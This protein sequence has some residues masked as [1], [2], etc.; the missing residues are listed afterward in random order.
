[1]TIHTAGDCSSSPKRP[2]T[3]RSIHS[4]NGSL[5]IMTSR[6]ILPIAKPLCATNGWLNCDFVWQHTYW[7][8]LFCLCCGACGPLSRADSTG[9]F[10]IIKK[11]KSGTVVWRHLA[12]PWSKGAVRRSGAVTS[13]RYL[14]GRPCQSRCRCF[15]QRRHGARGRGSFPG[16][17][18]PARRAPRGGRRRQLCI[19]KNDR[20]PVLAAADDDDL[21]I[22]RLRQLKRCFDAAPTQIRFRN[23]LADGL[24]EIA[25][26]FCLDPLAFRFSFFALDP[27][28]IFFSNVVLLCLAIDGADYGR[29][30]FDAGHQYVIT[31]DGV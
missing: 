16:S 5:I 14:F 9:S 25:N 22:P 26:A 21:R 29:G 17:V 12:Q 11:G 10:R 15:L 7:R 1:M 8:W 13:R 4:T 6:S 28:L 19:A 18:V 30:Q 23:A 3:R 27:K 31:N 20:Q 2:Y 24:L